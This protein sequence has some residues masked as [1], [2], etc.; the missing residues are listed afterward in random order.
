MVY[1][2]DNEPDDDD[3]TAPASTNAPTNVSPSSKAPVQATDATSAPAD[4]ACGAHVAPAKPVSANGPSPGSEAGQ[5]GSVEDLLA[6][7]FAK[8][9]SDPVPS[10][11]APS[12]PVP[13]RTPA[14][15]WIPWSERSTVT[16][17]KQ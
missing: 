2:P 6:N 16:V 7:M 13:Y 10:D 12:D 1:E 17:P 9:A 3:G 15:P 5:R 4:G 14:K 8:S 11:S